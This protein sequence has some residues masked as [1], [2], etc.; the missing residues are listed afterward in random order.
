MKILVV[1]DDPAMRGLVKRTLT[2]LGHQVTEAEDG[3]Q[4]WAE[5]VLDSFPLLISDW[6]MPEMDGLELTRLIRARDTSKYTYVILLTALEGKNRYL[7]GMDAGADDFITKPFDEDQLA[8]R[9]RVAERILGLQARNRELT[10]LIPICMYCTA[11]ECAT[12]PTPR[13][14]NRWTH[15]SCDTPIRSSATA[16]VPNT[17]R[18]IIRRWRKGSLQGRASGDCPGA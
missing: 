14:G 9:I 7:E 8:A 5:F 2:Q 11:R 6:L 17:C 3:R 18:S 10:A 1:D 13:T 16:S 4:A 15:T 12:T